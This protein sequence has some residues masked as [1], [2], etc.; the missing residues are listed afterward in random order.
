M[1]VQSATWI[2]GISSLYAPFGKLRIL[3]FEIV[4]IVDKLLK[5]VFH[6]KVTIFNPDAVSFADLKVFR[7]LVRFALVKY[8]LVV[9]FISLNDRQKIVN[10]SLV[11]KLVHKRGE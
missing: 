1:Q 8:C 10:H 3:G 11:G 4:E 2:L 6:V 9:Y 5:K 7:L